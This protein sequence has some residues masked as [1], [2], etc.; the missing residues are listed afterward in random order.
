[1][2][3]REFFSVDPWP[4]QLAGVEETIKRIEPGKWIC[5]CSPTGG[6]KSKMMEALTRYA[7]SK[8][9]GVDIKVH[10]KLLLSQLVRVFKQAR[11]SFGVRA[12]S[13]PELLD[14]DKP[15]QISSLPTELARCSGPDAKW[16]LHKAGLVL[17]DE[18]HLQNS[19]RTVE[20]LRRQADAGATI[21]GVTATPIGMCS[22]YSDI[23]VAGTNSELRKAKAHV[24]AIVKAPW[25]LDLG[26][27]QREKTGEFRVG[28][29]VKNLWSQAIIGSIID[30]WRHCNPDERQTL[31]F[32]PD[33]KS[34][35]WIAEQFRDAGVAS[36]HIDGTSVWH[37]GELSNDTTGERRK[38]VLDL[39]AEGEVKI[40]CNRFVMREGIDLPFIY[41]LTLATPIGSLKTFIQ[42]VGRVL[43]YSPQTP[44]HVVICDHGGNVWRHGSPN[45]DRDWERLFWM[46]EEEV[47]AEERERNKKT[48]EDP[49]ITCP[50]CGTV[51][52]Q[53]PTCP[54][55]PIGCGRA[56]EFRGKIIIQKSGKLK[57]ITEEEMRKNSDSTKTAQQL[58][59]AFYYAS[60]NSKS[61]RKLTFSQLSVLF[62]RKHGYYPPRNLLRM[63]RQKWQW[64]MPVRDIQRSELT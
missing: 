31:L 45:A 58:W 51:R 35:I 39:F 25:E 22:S 12:A 11:I 53:G 41:N 4:H 10:R 27:I 1:M 48:E 57:R 34:S 21:I 14:L 32:A 55:P 33:V 59:D 46:T 19:P 49:P 30:E 3:A 5:L 18:A 2:D 13:L 36:A 24:P 15:V 61:S 7:L 42:T 28:D 54:A 47:F 64:K 26:R 23:V 50:N 9:Q 56:N 16:E 38:F 40:V 60:A 20:L 37:D 62:N 6:G 43:R 17:V 44:D 8:N 63:P 29:S 52:A